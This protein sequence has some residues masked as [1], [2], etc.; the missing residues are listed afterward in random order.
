MK[1]VLV[2]PAMPAAL[3]AGLVSTAGCVADD[4]DPATS[5]SSHA[6]INGDPVADEA[7][8][9]SVVA[10]QTNKGSLCTGTL[11][12]PTAVLT[13][14]HC[15]DPQFLVSEPGQ[16]PPTDV[17]FTVT[18]QNNLR[19][20]GGTKL[21][22]KSVEFHDGFPNLDLAEASTNGPKEFKDIAIVHLKDPVKD[23]PYQKLALDGE[24][25]AL[26][27]VGQTYKVVGYGLTSNTDNMAAGVL[28]H[29]VSDLDTI[30][31]FEIAVGD[32]DDQQACRGDSGGPVMSQDDVQLG[33]ASRINMALLP[34][35]TSP[36][37]CVP[38]LLYTRVDAY[39]DWIKARV[40]DLP[41]GDGDGDDDTGGC[42][43]RTS[44]SSGAT[45]TLAGLAVL[46]VIT[47]RRRRR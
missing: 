16:P 2:R 12:S 24:A 1:R 45:A 3:L 41:G 31:S 7:A 26:L 35:P 36:P 30:G 40:T 38:G 8:F 42:G 39:A 23:R 18:F 20:P 13:A 47:R 25:E 46:G 4:A 14:A 44:G 10:V 43:C 19:V 29:G 34:P 11:I 17:V 27:E 37:P 6:V 5:T 22:V 21:A 15:V 33:I 9:P 28:T 32:Q